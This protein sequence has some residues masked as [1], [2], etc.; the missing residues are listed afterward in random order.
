MLSNLAYCI[1]VQRPVKGATVFSSSRGGR[2]LLWRRGGG[3][4]VQLM[5]SLWRWPHRYQA[6]TAIEAEAQ[7]PADRSLAICRPGSNCRAIGLYGLRNR[8]VTST[9]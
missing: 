2:S 4:R 8:R 6:S 7:G 3:S 9:I 1:G 5:R